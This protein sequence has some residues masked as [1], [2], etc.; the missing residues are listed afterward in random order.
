MNKRYKIDD[1]SEIGFTNVLQ[2]FLIIVMALMC[3]SIVI[4]YALANDESLAEKL[5]GQLLLRVEK[6]GQL[7]YVDPE[8]KVKLYTANNDFAFSLFRARGV[9]VSNAALERIPVGEL[10]VFG[11]DTDN[12]GLSDALEESIGTN[13][14]KRDTDNDGYSD[15]VEIFNHFNP[16]GDGRLVFDGTAIDSMKGFFLIQMESKQQM[17]YLN[18]RDGKRY[19]I[20]NPADLNFLIKKVALGINEENF[21]LIPEVSTSSLVVAGE[22]GVEDGFVSEVEDDEIKTGIF[23]DFWNKIK[24]LIFFRFTSDNIE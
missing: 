4:N 22:G 6:G 15:S 1:C 3:G 18:P 9:R 5:K 19:F 10:P 17:W 7:W 23:E 21:S 11:Q 12:D 16:V 13:S 2:F 14:S 8:K 20:S 24:Y